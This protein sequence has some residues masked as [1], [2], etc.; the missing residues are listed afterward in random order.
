[1]G[2]RRIEIVEVGPRD[3]LQNEKTL[4]EVG[5]KLEMIARLEAAGARRMEVVSFVN[6]KRVPQMAG[7]EE[8]MAALPHKDGRSR[9]GLVLNMR[10]WERCRD[11]GCDEANVVVCASDGFGIRNQ[12]ASVDEQ[13]TALADIMGVRKK[14]DPPVTMTVSVAFG[15]PFDGEVPEERVVEIVKA[16]ADMRVAEIA[17]ADTI[18]VA[19]PWTV[20]RRVEAAKKAAGHIPL[21]LHFHDTRNTGLANA[22][23][24][25]E[26]GVDVLDASVGGLGG[27]PF[28]PN[29]TGNI[30]TEDLVYML[31]RA[32]YETGYDLDQLIGIGVWASDLLGKRVASS[33]AKAGGFPKPQPAAS[34]AA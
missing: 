21:R 26:A 19:D 33:V 24:G 22:F 17:L 27:C 32:G 23:A 11:A 4:F 29:A 25:V 13:V 7:A 5:Q 9:I 30:G 1:M 34:S 10:G 6:P 15:C 31:E 20:R 2:R 18:G 16:A 14:E 3:G 12:G 8:I 28:A